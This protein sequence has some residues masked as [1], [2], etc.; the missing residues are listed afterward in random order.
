ML[1][2]VLD[3]GIKNAL[4]STTIMMKLPVVNNAYLI[5]RNTWLLHVFNCIY[6]PRVLIRWWVQG[7]S[8]NDCITK[9]N[10]TQPGGSRFWLVNML[11]EKIPKYGTLK[12]A[13]KSIFSPT[14]AIVGWKNSY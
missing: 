2:L 12:S 3:E 4:D 7:G 9:S 1:I 14:S 13:T 5:E 10:F 11:P 8:V 6:A